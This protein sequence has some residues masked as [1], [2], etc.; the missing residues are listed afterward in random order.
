[1]LKLIVPGLAAVLLAVS[2]A[3]QQPDPLAA[4]ATALG[5]DTVKSLQFTGSGASF[6]VGQPYEASAAWPRLTVESYTATVDYQTP[7]MRLEI[8]RTVPNP[9]P[10]GIAPFTGQQ[11][12][13]LMLSGDYGW[14]VPQP[15]AGAPPPAT[16]PAPTPA[17]DAVVTERKLFLWATPHGFVKAAAANKATA[18][19]SGAATEITFMV[20]G[21]HR[22]VGRLNAQNQVERV[23]TWIDNPVMGDMLIET[24]YAGYRDFG[25]VNFPA[26]V[27]QSQGGHPTLDLTISAVTR[28]PTVDVTVPATVSKP[29]T[30]PAAIQVAAE[31]VAPEVQYL[32]GGTHHSVAIGMRDHVV[33]VEGPQSEARSLAVIARTKALYPTKPIRY[34]VNTHVHFDHSGGLR[35]FVDEGAIVVTHRSNQPFFQ[36]AWAASRTINPD[37][38]AQSKK[39]A[40]FQAVGDRG[41]LSD[42]SRVID[43]YTIASSHNKGILAAYLPAEKI[44][45]QADLYSPLAAT[46]PPPATPNPFS[47][48]LANEIDR[49]KLDVAKILALHGP[50]VT[51]M[52]D[53]KAAIGRSGTKH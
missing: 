23:Q 22:V 39:G 1:M 45:I 48:E 7:G 32:T 46:A 19:R 24:T 18:R 15:A 13:V 3:A 11:R 6:N 47:I 2:I 43:L 29:A 27:Q 21:K 12:Q 35:P 26:R 40:R 16:P 53:L 17:A 51:T 10:P 52:E 28:N 33:V 34:I 44:L 5:T 8:V 49:L 50:R 9:V 42:G 30:A 14:N 20:D 38:L 41:Q 37:R 25:G 4:A 36:K 31:E